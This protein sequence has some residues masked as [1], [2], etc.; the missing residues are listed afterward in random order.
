[1]EQGAEKEA[2]RRLVRDD[3]DAAVAVLLDDAKERRQRARRDLQPALA[4][5]RRK[6]KRVMLVARVLLGELAL[7]LGARLS[8]PPPVRDLADAVVRHDLNPVRRG[9][10][11]RGVHGALEGAGVR[12]GDLLAGQALAETPRLLAPG[13][14]EEDVDR[15]G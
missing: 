14:G 10:E 11:A 1:P 2:D 15:A 8:L 5:Q 13:V 4:L 12:D 9:D 7:H 3:E 6:R